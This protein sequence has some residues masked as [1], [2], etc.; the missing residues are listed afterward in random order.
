MSDLKD[1]F[2][3]A[4]AEVSGEGYAS[5][6]ESSVSTDSNDTTD[7]EALSYGKLGYKRVQRLRKK[8]KRRN[9]E[10]PY[11]KYELHKPDKPRIVF[12]IIAVLA[13]VL[14][15][16]V[17]VGGVFAV[18]LF[19]KTQE[20]FNGTGDLL[21]AAFRPEVMALSLGMSVL[22]GLMIVFAYAMLLLICLIP[23]LVG[24]YLIS[25]VRNALYLARCSKEE[26]AKGYDVS[27]RIQR[28]IVAIVLATVLLIVAIYASQ[29]K[30]VVVPL[31]LVYACV[32][33]VLGGF[34]AILLIERSKN[35]KWFETLDEAQKENFIQHDAGLRKVNRRLKSERAY[36]D[37]FG[38]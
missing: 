15:I 6:S 23:I 8:G 12:W 34:L 2:A 11:L 33:A 13:A 37:T 25:Y 27:G 7:Y 35:L 18:H 31:V 1:I 30:T 26:F 16:G 20:N 5:E 3:E 14:M 17:I 4:E 38:R 9:I 36:W 32:V 22:P 19:V 21:K 28:L 29:T 24:A 10:V